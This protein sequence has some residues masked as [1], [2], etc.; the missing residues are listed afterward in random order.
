MGSRMIAAGFRAA[1]LRNATATAAGWRLVAP[2]RAKYLRATSAAPAPGEVMPKTESSPCPPPASL[3]PS[4]SP[5][6]PIIGLR[7]PEK[8]TAA[9]QATALARPAL[10]AIAAHW[11]QLAVK[12]P[13]AQVWLYSLSLSPRV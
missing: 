12:R 8:L 11:R 7:K 5:A 4:V 1:C 13:C 9:R 10:T 6:P 3:A 2:K